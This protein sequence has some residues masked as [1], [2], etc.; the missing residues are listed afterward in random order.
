M[1]K[2]IYYNLERNLIIIIIGISM[3]MDE[4]VKQ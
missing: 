3:L 1:N 4:L 2:K